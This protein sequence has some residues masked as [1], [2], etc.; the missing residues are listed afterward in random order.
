MPMTQ[1]K[2]AL[3]IT[4]AAGFIGSTFVRMRAAEGHDCIVLDAL[5]YAGFRGNL[6]PKDIPG[7]GTVRLIEGDINDTERV[8]GILQQYPITGVF[9]F[10]AESHVDRSIEGPS[11]FISTNINGTFHLLN[12]ALTYWN[13]LPAGSDIKRG[14]K[15][16]QVSTDEVYGSLGDTGLFSEA[17][18]YMPRSPYAASKA[19]AD[20][21]VRAWYHTYG[22]PTLVTTCSN[23]YGPRQFPEKLIPLMIRCALQGA[24][25]PV[26]GKG[27]NVRDWIH[28]EDHCEGVWLAYQKGRAGETYGFGGSAERRNLDVVQ[29]ICQILDELSPRADGKSYIHQIA[30]VKDRL[31][32]DWRYA[33]DDRKAQRELGFTRKTTSFEAGLRRTVQWYLENQDWV[34]RVLRKG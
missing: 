6:D 24:P 25:L 33:T 27:E 19:A 4:G 14:F 2:N 22:L 15:F 16:V 10:A 34:E 28:V 29:S 26:Y 13:G 32:H 17:S 12:E 30:F 3:L 8:R 5:T 11:A 23:N 20:H 1:R 18:P 7:P 31:G 21:L 9:N